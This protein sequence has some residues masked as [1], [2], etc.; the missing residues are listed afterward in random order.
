MLLVCTPLVGCG[1]ADAAPNADGVEARL[2]LTAMGDRTEGHGAAVGTLGHSCSPI[3]ARAV[4]NATGLATLTGSCG[5][6]WGLSCAASMTTVAGS[7]SGTGQSC[8]VR[9]AGQ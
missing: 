3:G 5:P 9:S 1:G 8:G 6:T 2:E 7:F 4:D